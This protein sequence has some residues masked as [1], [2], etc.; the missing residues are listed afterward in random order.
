MTN[1]EQAKELCTRLLLIP[2]EGY[3]KK[4]PNGDCKSYPD[5]AS[6]GIPWT[7]G[8]G[9]T[10]HS[11]GTSVQPN[12]VWTK[13]Y[14][15]K[16]KQSVLNKFLVGLLKLSPNLISESP[17][18]IA[19]VLSLVYNIGLGNYSISKLRRKIRDKDYS[20]IESCFLPWNTAK[21][22]GVRRVYRGLTRRRQA[23]ADMFN[24]G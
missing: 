5:P 4:L 20:N 18:R 6:G 9:S 7:I 23:E 2:F 14:A 17:N 12:E 21:E 13:D 11:D 1:L 16:V 24:L 15:I 3:A 19:A 22:N 10:Y 8:Y